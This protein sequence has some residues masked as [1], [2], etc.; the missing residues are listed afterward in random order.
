MLS[1]SDNAIVFTWEI[2]NGKQDIGKWEM[3]YEEGNRKVKGI[4][5]SDFLEEMT[6]LP[7][8]QVNVIFINNL[9]LF[10]VISSLYMGYNDN[11]KAG[12]RDRSINFFFLRPWEFVE[13]RNSNN[14]WADISTEEFL[15]RLNLCRENFKGRKR[16][17]RLGLKNHFVYTL[18]KDL[19]SEICEKYYLTCSSFEKI[20]TE[21][22]PQNETELDLLLNIYKASFVY[23]NPKYSNKIV[24]NVYSRD[25]KSSHSGIYLRK[26][27]PYG[28]G[29]L[30]EDPYEALETMKNDYYAWI[31]EFKIVGLREKINDFPWDMRNFG[32]QDKE[33]NWIIKLT[34]VHWKVFKNIYGADQLIPFRMVRYTQKIL[35]KNY[36]RMINELYQEKEH[37]KKTSNDEFVKGLFKMRTELPYGQSIKN[38]VYYTSVIYDMR[39]D[40]FIIDRLP[41][42]TFTE[43]IGRLKKYAFPF[44]YGIWTAAY[45]WAEEIEM[46]TKIGLDKVIYGD[47][48]SVKFLGEEGIK[49]IEQHNKE[50]DSEFRIV[51]TKYNLYGEID[52][53]IGRW[54]DDGFNT[55]FKTLGLKR[56][57]SRKKDGTIKVTCAGAMISTLQRYFENSEN[58]FDEFEKDMSI[59]GIYKH[60]Y[61]DRKNRI[62]DVNF[63]N[64]LEEVSV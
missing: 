39:E 34:N 62:V 21:L 8:N 50:I 31:G 33:G 63:M 14:F 35:D 28:N 5:M 42:P 2:L 36:I 38:P 47:T 17:N 3:L 54:H 22:L 55:E 10:Q 37:F 19:W 43:T 15:R 40:N 49:I 1:Y 13:F 9:N 30:V 24:K 26:K 64:Y 20:R 53:K 61:I 58:P 52:K 48:D 27:Y 29:E 46:I 18:V 56:Y 41:T 12:V 60:I 59:E 4:G 23:S 51:I 32:F 7:Q 6:Q 11:F 44:Q 25:I 16:K 45:S 57:L